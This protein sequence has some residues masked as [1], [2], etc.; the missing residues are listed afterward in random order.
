MATCVREHAS[1]QVARAG[2]LLEAET[3][4]TRVPWSVDRDADSLRV[5]I[6]HPIHGWDDLIKEIERNLVPFPDAVY[7]PR[8]LRDATDIDRQLLR[9]LWATLSAQGLMLF[10]SPDAE[11]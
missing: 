4:L 9:M 6:E 2:T 1:G 11:R 3:S 8:N 5:H 10:P 7:L